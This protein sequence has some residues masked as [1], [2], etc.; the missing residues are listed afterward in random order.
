METRFVTH[1]KGS[2]PTLRV[3]VSD[4]NSV[5]VAAIET[6]GT[7]ILD[8]FYGCDFHSIRR[9][10]FTTEKVLWGCAI[11]FCTAETISQKGTISSRWPAV[12]PQTPTWRLD[13][14]KRRRLSTV[15]CKNGTR[16]ET[17]WNLGTRATITVAQTRRNHQ[18]ALFTACADRNDA[19]TA[20]SQET[21]KAYPM[22]MFVKPWSH[23]CTLED[24]PN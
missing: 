3:V 1:D 18:F 22:H 23:P 21:S 16:I 19:K 14:Y 11:C 24:A 13:A 9:T 17:S 12:P 2:S 6:P 10:A 8:S 7:T 4:T 15:S 5:L 20:Q